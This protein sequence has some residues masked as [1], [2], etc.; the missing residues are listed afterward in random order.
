MLSA[1]QCPDLESCFSCELLGSANA[2]STPG[3]NKPAGKR[4]GGEG[5][6][7]RGEKCS[8]RGEKCSAAGEKCFAGADEEPGQSVRSRVEVGVKAN[9]TTRRCEIPASAYIALA[10]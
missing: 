7:A 5:C 8:A 3:T 2:R 6:S 10:E 9:G 4:A 1:S